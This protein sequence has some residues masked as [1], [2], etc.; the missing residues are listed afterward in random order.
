[1]RSGFSDDLRLN[2]AAARLASALFYAKAEAFGNET[3][4]GADQDVATRHRYTE[5]AASLLR[6]VQPQP[7]MF[8][9]GLRSA[10]SKIIGAISP[11]GAA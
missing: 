6:S 11:R 9:A 4:P 10:T 7:I 1:M 8:A 2:A 3:Q 5:I